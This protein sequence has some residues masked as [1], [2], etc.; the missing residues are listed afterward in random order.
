MTIDQR[1]KS[2]QAIADRIFMDFKYTKAGSDEQLRAF[3]TL[4]SLIS[5]WATY[6]INDEWVLNET[7]PLKLTV[8]SSSF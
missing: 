7:A 6:I 2:Q 5:M 8:Q 1:C 4:H 3:E